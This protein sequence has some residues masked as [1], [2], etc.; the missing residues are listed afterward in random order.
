MR[1]DFPDRRQGHQGADAPHGSPL[2]A[3]SEGQPA[4]R[5]ENN[6]SHR[7]AQSLR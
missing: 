4:Q 6:D 7:F 5:A 3:C 2:R 1:S